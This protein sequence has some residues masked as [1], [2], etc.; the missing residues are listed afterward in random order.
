MGFNTKD[1]RWQAMRFERHKGKLQ[2]K[3]TKCPACMREMWFS[4]FEPIGAYRARGGDRKPKKA[5]ATLD[6]LVPLSLGGTFHVAN[7]TTMCLECN[8]D[9]AARDPIEWLSDLASKNIARPGYIRK[10][11]RRAIRVARFIETNRSQ[12]GE[13]H[14]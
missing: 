6:H 12:K 8:D 9:K 10:Q 11:K 14:G 4:D 13:N 5:V 2:S 3:R 7:L 1:P